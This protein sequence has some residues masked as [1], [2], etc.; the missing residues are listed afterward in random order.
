MQLLCNL[1]SM[2]IETDDTGA[3]VRQIRFI[4][5]CRMQQMMTAQKPSGPVSLAREELYDEIRSRKPL[6]EEREKYEKKMAGGLCR[7]SGWRNCGCVSVYC[8]GDDGDVSGRRCGGVSDGVTDAADIGNQ[9]NSKI[10][11]G[12][13]K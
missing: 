6:Q 3:F 13:R 5:A 4:H 7:G 8:N 1:E 11:V 9:A 2:N 12:E 10:P